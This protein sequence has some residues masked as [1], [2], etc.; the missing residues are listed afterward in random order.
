MKR[1]L[2]SSFRSFSVFSDV[3]PEVFKV[4]EEEEQEQEQQDQG[5]N[6]NECTHAVNWGRGALRTNDQRLRDEKR[7]QIRQ[8]WR[9]LRMRKMTVLLIQ[10]VVLK[11]VIH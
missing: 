8:T 7:N 4:I 1:K 9:R 3:I 6:Q 5:E 2:R 11:S 10:Q